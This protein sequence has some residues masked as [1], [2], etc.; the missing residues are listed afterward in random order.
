MSVAPY[1]A[2]RPGVARGPWYHPL[3]DG[4]VQCDLCPRACRLK[5]GQRGFC[6]VRRAESNSVVLDSYGR[7]SGFCI[8]PIEKKPLNHFY[9]GSSV[10]SF[11]T[12][13]CNLGCKF[14]Q[15]WDI[16]K[17]RQFDRLTDQASPTAIARDA[18]GNGCTSIAYT[19]NDPVIFA[20]FAIDCAVAAHELGLKNVAVTAGYITQLARP[21]F[22]AHMDAANIDLKAF[23]EEY[24]RKQCYGHLQPV[25]ET[26]A[27]VHRETDVWLEVTT[28]LIPG[29]NDAD[30]ELGAMCEWFERNLGRDV[31]LHFTAFHP[32]FKVTDRDHT[33]PATLTR[34][35]NIAH[36]VGL[37]YVY[38][39]NVDDSAGQSTYC[40]N[41]GQVLIERNRYTLG[42]W[43]LTDDA[44]CNRCGHHLPGRFSS[45]PGM[46]GSRRRRL[47]I[48]EG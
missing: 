16:S 36:S 20:E 31:P 43:N 18:H 1:G 39:G 26:L 23:S 10:L 37:N 34:A 13:G 40:S 32:D 38:T 42:T 44:T 46:W 41:C 21:D 8:D 4:R 28:L 45:E 29:L 5:E 15:N 7:A 48:A 33:P 14:C 35:R 24:Y 47:R 22:Y 12:A 3:D 11:G 19:Y 25:L 2:L 6:Y 27:W 30:S 17:A 9:P